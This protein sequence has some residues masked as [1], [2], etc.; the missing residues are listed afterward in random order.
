MPIAPAPAAGATVIEIRAEDAQRRARRAWGRPAGCLCCA[1]SCPRADAAAC[2]RRLARHRPDPARLSRRPA[3]DWQALMAIDDPRPIDA[4]RLWSRGNGHGLL[5]VPIGVAE[6]GTVVELDIKEAARNGMGPHGLCVGATGSGK[7]EFLRTLMLG[8]IATHP[9]EVLN[10]VLVDF[11]G[12]ATF[13]GLD[14]RHARV[15]GHH[16]P[17]RRGA[18]GRPD[19]GCA[20]R[21]DEPQAGTAQG[22]G[23]PRECRRLRTRPR[24][25]AAPAA[26]ARAVHR[27]R[28]VL[29]TAQPAPRLRR[30]VRR[31]RTAG[32]LA[33][34]AS[35][36]GQPAARRG[37][38]A[39][40][41]DPSVLPDLPEDVLG[42][43]VPGGARRPRRLPPAQRA[44]RGVPEDRIRR[45]DAIP[46]RLRLGPIR[47][48]D[49]RTVRSAGHR[50]RCSALHAAAGGRATE[51]VPPD[52]A[53]VARP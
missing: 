35:A 24:R 1:T 29:R 30:V 15:G 19:A 50:R 38:A 37:P 43:R 49:D 26:A 47:R 40:A 2:A 5:R 33:G 9:P 42:Q 39:R 13:L 8:M 11:K 51:P 48:R 20:R 28:R 3:R 4:D 44:G 10:L 32:P 53:A 36:A 12:G 46:D 34:H 17:G 31:D 22:G 6:D 25:K 23:Q 21:R 14:R 41:G 7:S 16:Q 45:A 18:P 52:G 27:R